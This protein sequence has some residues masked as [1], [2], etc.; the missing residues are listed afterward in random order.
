MLVQVGKRSTSSDVVD[1]LLECHDRIRKFL[2]M[3]RS[4]AAATGAEP[5]EIRSVAA[6]VRRYFGES[7]PL[8]VADEHEQILPRLAGTD[9][10]V[11]RALAA[12]EA[13]HAEHEPLVARLIASCSDLMQD[14]GRLDSRAAELADVVERLSAELVRHLELEER[15]VLPAVRRLPA[16]DRDAILAAMRQRRAG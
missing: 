12:M 4:L 9:A 7:L 16:S 13:E 5:E 1:L 6:Q 8:H 2:T 14:P 15:V 10:E 3:A 11:D